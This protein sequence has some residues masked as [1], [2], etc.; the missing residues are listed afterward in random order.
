MPRPR[1]YADDAERRRAQDEARKQARVTKPVKFVAIDGE[2]QGQWKNHTY[3]LLGIGDASIEDTGGLTFEKIAA[4]L[5]EQYLAQTNSVFA[6]F[7]LGYDFSQ[8][9]SKLPEERAR[10]LFNPEMRKRKSKR[11]VSRETGEVEEIPSRLGPWPVEY[12]GWEFDLLGMKRMKLRKEGAKEWMYVCDTGSF[13]QEPFMGVID[14]DKWA[15]PVVTQ[16]EYDILKEGKKKRDVAI[17]DSDMRKYNAL[18]NDVL[19]RVLERL[20]QGLRRAGVRLKRD[21]WFG[22]GQAAQKWLDHVKC[23][24]GEMVR[25]KVPRDG[26]NGDILH[27]GRLTYYGGW[28][29]IFAHGHIPGESYEY[30]INSAYP[31]ISSQLPCLLHGQWRTD[32][33]EVRRNCTRNL[34]RIVHADV[35]G[36]D[37]VCGTMLHRRRDHSIVRPHRT[38]GWYW[39][40][41]LAAG[42]RAG[43]IDEV[44]VLS[45]VEY[46][47]CDCPSPLRGL[48]GLYN[49][50][51]RVG[52]NTPEGKAFKL[53]YNSVYGKFAQS[54]GNP[55]YGNSIYASLITSGT[56]TMILD[57]IATHP[58]GTNDLVMV[59]TDG[60]YFRTPH[61]R[62]PL[63]DDMG[64]WEEAQK[65]NLT[66]FKPGVYWDD[67]ARNRINAGKDPRFKARGISAKAF[68]RSISTI[69]DT[70]Q[71]WNN[72][73]SQ[74]YPAITFT[75][76][77][78]MITPLQALQR[79]KW[80]LAGTLGHEP[81]ELC[82]GCSGQHLRQ[83][84]DP[85]QK[86]KGPLYADGDIWRSSPWETGGPELDSVPYDRA[87]GQPDPEEYGITDD[88]TVLDGWRI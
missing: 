68:A 56:R 64:L 60:V 73:T 42:I 18:E 36:N 34:F 40:S 50:R 69:D 1:K 54:I 12:R 87:F 74:D 15:E 35:S 8:W 86:R 82:S 9:L 51:L 77:F 7:F 31:F 13:F 43:V 83:D 85:V 27:K 4:F 70:F 28:F 2:G 44:E 67:N 21:E 59:A 32:N 84:S 10:R 62:L 48:A 24:T 49:E 26:T 55:K 45:G 25:A 78:S 6:G 20:D 41:E 22:P 17:L 76:G 71:R 38:R 80:Q 61:N 29:E 3:V 19:P 46:Q 63:G 39:E 53:I 30:D 11:K 5:W 72:G 66:L 33:S 14:P 79:G 52:K 23:P 88:G 65:Q 81:S 47:P 57:S 58:R 16:A 75:S 37:P